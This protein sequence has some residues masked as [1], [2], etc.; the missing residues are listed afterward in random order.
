MTDQYD[1]ETDTDDFFLEFDSP[2]EYDEF[3]KEARE[4]LEGASDE[5]ATHFLAYVPDGV[6]DDGDIVAAM[7]VGQLMEDKR[8]NT[9]DLK[10]LDGSSA[11][12][13]LH[14]E[15]ELVMN[16]MFD[17]ATWEGEISKTVH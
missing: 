15:D 16:P 11:E 5:K 8:I 7:Y 4:W 9:K 6:T 12:I 14:D 17:L 13:Q 1:I 10:A 3:K 2:E